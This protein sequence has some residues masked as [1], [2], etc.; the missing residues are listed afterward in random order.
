M[1]C[2]ISGEMI[3]EYFTKPLQGSLFQ[4]FMNIIL[5][6]LFEVFEEDDMKYKGNYSQVSILFGVDGKWK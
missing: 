5:G 1:Y 2:P 6:I 4:K 3:P